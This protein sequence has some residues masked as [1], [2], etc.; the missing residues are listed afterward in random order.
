MKSLKAT[1]RQY[2]ITNHLRFRYWQRTHKKY[3]HLQECRKTGCSDCQ[4]LQ[5]EIEFTIKE[6][7]KEIDDEIYQRL[8]KSKESRSCVNNSNFM[9]WY[10][11]KYGYDT[12]FEFLVDGDVLFVIIQDRSKKIVVTCLEAK[13]HVA[14]KAAQR[15]KF[16]KQKQK[17]ELVE[18]HQG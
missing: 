15:P 16:K 11:E 6:N 12:R 17:K 9:T 4:T 1:R 14:G 7:R 13:T 3:Q 8:L 10:Y 18:V 5:V 2:I